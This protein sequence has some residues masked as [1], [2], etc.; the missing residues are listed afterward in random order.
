[1]EQKNVHIYR[2]VLIVICLV[3]SVIAFIHMNHSYDPLARYPYQVSEEQRKLIL[4]HLNESDIDYLI[5][6]QIEPKE[7]IPF[8]DKEGF[9]IK[10]SYLYTE[11]MDYQQAEPE[12]IVN[13]INRYRSHFNKDSLSDLLQH[14]TYEDLINFYETQLILHE[15]MTLQN[16]PDDPYLILN[17]NKTV[18]K[19]RPADLKKVKN[20]EMDAEAAAQLEKMMADYEL[21]A[22]KE[23]TLEFLN[24]YLP[25]ESL[26]EKRITLEDIFGINTNQLF[27]NGGSNEFQLGYSLALKEA[28]K[29]QDLLAKNPEVLESHDYS[30]VLQELSEQELEELNWIQKNCWR[31]GFIVRYPKGAEDQTGFIWQ[32]FVLRYV[33]EENAKNMRSRSSIME[34]FT[35]EEN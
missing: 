11:A 25:Y 31:Y 28:E 30:K 24:G 35:F 14:Y 16:N 2:I 20:I 34:N 8:V 27:L 6:Q 12:F 1:M 7:F 4:D 9:K 26:L 5:T 23:D 29:W 3:V 19:Y 13:F 15:N 32:P 17:E 21:L 18:Y 10:N 33:G 22:Q